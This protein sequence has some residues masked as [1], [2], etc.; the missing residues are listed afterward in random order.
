MIEFYPQIKLVHI[1]AVLASGALLLL[2]GLAVQLGVRGAMAA[3]TRYLSYCI[4]TVLLTAALMLMTVLHQ[5]P[6]AQLWLTVKIALVVLY[7]ILGSFALKRGRTPRARLACLIAALL[8]YGMIV[9]IA[10]TH[11][12]LGVFRSISS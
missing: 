12:P 4:D 2:R 1:G 7:V 6:F 9:S 10:W 11:D 3:P 8:V 5:Y